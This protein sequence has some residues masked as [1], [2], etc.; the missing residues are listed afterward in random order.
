[1]KVKLEAIKIEFYASV[2]VNSTKTF[3]VNGKSTIVGEFE[4]V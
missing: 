2:G 4:D 1:M 3:I